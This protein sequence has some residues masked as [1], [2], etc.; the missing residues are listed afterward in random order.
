VEGIHLGVVVVEGKIHSWVEENH[1]VVVEVVRS[2]AVC[3]LV[4]VIR[5]VVEVVGGKIHS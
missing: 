5:L 4:E 2:S 3:P 1:L